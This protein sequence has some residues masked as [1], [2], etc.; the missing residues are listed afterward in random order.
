[1]KNINR[2]NT[3]DIYYGEW[4]QIK[5]ALAYIRIGYD[6]EVKFDEV[7]DDIFYLFWDLF[8]KERDLTFNEM[9]DGYLKKK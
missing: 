8:D 3:E 2:V 4:P 9:G 7:P 5:R 6:R 1:M